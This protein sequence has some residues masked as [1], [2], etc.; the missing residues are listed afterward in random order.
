MAPPH[1]GAVK[2]EAPPSAKELDSA[3]Q[4]LDIERFLF[5][6]AELLDQRRFD[7][8][9]ELFTKD[10]SYSVP[11][12]SEDID[13]DQAGALI[14]DDRDGIAAR[15]RRFQHPAAL[16]QVPAPRTRH[17]I[18]NVSIRPG[19]EHEVVVT[20][21]QLVYFTRRGRHAQY[22]GTWEHILQ[23]VDGEWRIRRKK[24]YL[25]TSDEAYS[26]LPIL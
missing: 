16:T 7:E 17:F 1:G 13:P 8:W 23:L 26:Q 14:L 11:N 5:W 4:R 6:E 2:R 22:P 19:P 21:N 12:D 25:I 10:A 3:A 24:V 20:S 18:T 9:L 15:V